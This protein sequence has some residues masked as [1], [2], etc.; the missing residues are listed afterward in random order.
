VCA[1]DVFDRWN[2]PPELINFA[3]HHLPVMHAIP[4]Q[5]DLPH[6]SYQ[7]IRRS[8][9]WTLVEAGALKL[10]EPGVPL[11]LEDW[12][13]FWGF[14]WGS[15]VEPIE[16][17]EP[18]LD[19]AVVHAY[20]WSSR[21]NA[22][23]GAAKASALKSWAPRLI[24]FDVALFGDNHQPF[25]SKCSG[26]LVFNHGTFFRR[27]KPDIATKPRVGVLMSSGRVNSIALDCSQDVVDER[28]SESNGTGVLGRD[29]LDALESIERDE[30][31]FCQAVEEALQSPGVSKRTIRTTREIIEHCRK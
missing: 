21:E 15:D 27:H 4:G 12:F 16:K 11:V 17:K 28:A 26:C 9:F 23:T 10:I 18:G 7:D 14:P 20:I 3:I 6:H 29:F 2:A 13:R 1:G 5:H 8:A 25:V 30:L 19:V 24:G 22:Y 31:D